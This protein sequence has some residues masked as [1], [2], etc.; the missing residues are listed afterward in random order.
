MSHHRPGLVQGGKLKSQRSS[1][2][3][4]LHQAHCRPLQ[5]LFLRRKV[6]S[7]SDVLKAT[8][9]R[10]VIGE[11][12]NGE[13]GLQEAFSSHGTPHGAPGQAQH[14]AK[15]AVRVTLSRRAMDLFPHALDARVGHLGY[16]IVKDL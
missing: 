3:P 6:T 4:I 5:T 11:N 1:F 16:K 14:S 13:G 8:R 7:R 2:G 12:A 10:V 9:S 15:D